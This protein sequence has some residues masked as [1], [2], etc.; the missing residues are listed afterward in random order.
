[1]IDGNNLSQNVSKNDMVLYF[2]E[3]KHSNSDVDAVVIIVI[4]MSC[5]IKNVQHYKYLRGCYN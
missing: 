2:R 3:V 1:M 4:T 5:C